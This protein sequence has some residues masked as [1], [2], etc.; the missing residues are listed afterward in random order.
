MKFS[1]KTCIVLAEGILKEAGLTTTVR[2]GRHL[3]LTARSRSGGEGHMT[4]A[5]SPRSD[6]NCQLNWSR[7]EAK[8]L[9]RALKTKEE[10]T[11]AAL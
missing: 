7:Q 4:F 9:V 6:L 2:H 3:R 1:Q 8:R 11:H 5:L 10:T